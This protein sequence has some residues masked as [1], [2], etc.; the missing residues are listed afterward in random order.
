M[1]YKIVFLI[2][3]YLVELMYYFFIV[4]KVV[5]LKDFDGDKE[6]FGNVEKFYV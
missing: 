4:K 5:M 3:D 2:I 1:K 6:K